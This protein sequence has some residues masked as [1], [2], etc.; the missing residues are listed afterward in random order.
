[1][2]DQTRNIIQKFAGIALLSILYSTQLASSHSIAGRFLGNSTTQAQPRNENEDSTE[3][4][5][6][7]SFTPLYLLGFCLFVPLCLHFCGSESN[8]E[9]EERLKHEQQVK[10]RQAEEDALV[11]Q[12]VQDRK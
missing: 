9:R 12:A 6:T 4:D 8:E 1:M 10:D 11:L 3:T 2:S 5:K 7:I